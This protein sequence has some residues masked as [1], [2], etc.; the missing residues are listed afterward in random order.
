MFAEGQFAKRWR[1]EYRYF[2]RGYAQKIPAVLIAAP[3]SPADPRLIQASVPGSGRC[4]RICTPVLVDD[5]GRGRKM[6]HRAYGS[7]WNR[8]IEHWGGRHLDEP[9]PSE[10]CQLMAYV[11]T[12]VVA[13]RNAR[14]GAQRR[15]A[16]SG[17]TPLPAPAG[18]G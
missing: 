10:I 12:H 14:G 17:S 4:G 5:P 9:T 6:I 1:Q 8:V 15:G 11:K 16:P 2:G 7:Y 18:G 3:H 13:R